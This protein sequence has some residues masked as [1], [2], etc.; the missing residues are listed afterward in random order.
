MA[1]IIAYIYMYG[2]ETAIKET[3]RQFE[4]DSACELR[5]ANKSERDIWYIDFPAYAFAVS[6]ISADLLKYIERYDVELSATR[7]N[8][9][10]DCI[11]CVRGKDVYSGMLTGFYLDR[12]LMRALASISLSLDFDPDSFRSNFT[13]WPK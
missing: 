8:G 6:T 9:V 11:L 1:H 7:S 12:P 13:L 3:F 4:D 2:C 10:V 5:K